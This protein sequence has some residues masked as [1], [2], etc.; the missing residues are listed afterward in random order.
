MADKIYQALG[1][2]VFVK[3]IEKEFTVGGLVIPDSIEN[4]FTYGE[5]ISCADV[6]VD[7]GTYVNSSI[8]VGDI[9]VFPKISGSKI[10]LGG[11]K[12]IRVRVNDIIAREV[13]GKVLN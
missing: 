1:Q 3:E 11:E 10:S 9:V 8:A 4:D 2:N 5:V 7:N 12:Y 13:E 6:Y